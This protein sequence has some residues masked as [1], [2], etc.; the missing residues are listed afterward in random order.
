MDSAYLVSL[1]ALSNRI[2]S[3]A[4]FFFIKSAIVYS[5]TEECLLISYAV[6]P[7]SNS[8]HSIFSLSA[9]IAMLPLDFFFII[10]L[11]CNKSQYQEEK[12]L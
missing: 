10:A 1:A 4:L 7:V 12:F 5:A 6:L 8:N 3:I 9:Y 11:F 2:F